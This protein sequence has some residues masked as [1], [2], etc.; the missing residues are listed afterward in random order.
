MITYQ[1]L[2]KMT[3]GESGKAFG[4][5]LGVFDGYHLGHQA[6]IDAARGEGRTGVLT[7]D[8]H[9]VEVLAPRKAPRKI[10][11]SL[12]HQEMVLADFGVDFLVVV[13][14]TREFANVSGREFAED[15]VATGVRRLAAGHDWSFGKGRSGNVDLLK[16]WVPEVQVTKVEAVLA[17]GERI[18]SSAIRSALT[19]GDLERVAAL[20]GRDYSVLGEVKQGKQL[21]RQ[22]GFPTANVEVADE[23][24]PSNGVYAISGR[25]QEE[26]IAG[27]ANV[28]TRPTVDDSMKRS[29]EVHLFSDEVPDRYG[30][31][32]EVAFHR[33]I[34]EEKKFASIEELK[35]QMAQDLLE[36]KGS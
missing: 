30:W 7:F 19:E 22:L 16:D 5:A 33:K 21:G 31:F 14:F 2:Q 24:L 18:S 27:V 17:D 3:A 15:L 8:P 28:G 4:L 29:L 36:A 32:L 11:G 35:A 10:M 23:L 9:P 26:W 34:R 20:L 1:G 12:A 6:V 13:E 25:W